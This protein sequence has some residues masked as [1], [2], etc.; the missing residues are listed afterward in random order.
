ML[1]ILVQASLSLKVREM[2]YLRR[3]PNLLNL[4]VVIVIVM[5]KLSE[6]AM[7]D[8]HRFIKNEPQNILSAWRVSH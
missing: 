5:S 1:I 3:V 2:K 7:R 4:T 8:Q 6:F